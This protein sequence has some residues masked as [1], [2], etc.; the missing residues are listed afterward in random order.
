MSDELEY[1]DPT[2]P[3]GVR[4]AGHFAR[5]IAAEAIDVVELPD[6]GAVEIQADDWTLHVEGDPITLAF[7]AIDQ[8][9]DRPG[10]LNAALRTALDADD[11]VA[12]RT[13]NEDLNG[14]LVDRLGASGDALS[15]ALVTLLTDVAPD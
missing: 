9:P 1:D 11:L 15:I 7:I 14:V 4:C 3:L 6:E 10:E 5:Q 8:E 12:L 2:T 13:L